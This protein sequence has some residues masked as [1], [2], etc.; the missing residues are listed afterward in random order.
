MSRAVIGLIAGAILAAAG[1]QAQTPIRPK[2][3]RSSVTGQSDSESRLSRDLVVV[4]GKAYDSKNQLIGPVRNGLVF[5]GGNAVAQIRGPD[6]YRG[7][8]VI[9][10]NLDDPFYAGKTVIVHGEAFSQNGLIGAVNGNGQ[11]I[12]SQGRVVGMAPSAPARESQTSPAPAGR[13]G[14]DGGN[15]AAGSVAAPTGGGVVGVGV[16]PAPEPMS[17][18]G[19][20]QPEKVGTKKHGS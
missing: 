15:T 10:V 19:G 9:G 2:P 8:K 20:S 11:I 12:N 16:G 7:G 18:P 1:V 13:G 17:L 5:L 6:V 14:Q 3:I 4:K